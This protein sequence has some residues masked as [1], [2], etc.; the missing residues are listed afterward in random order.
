MG[1]PRGKRTLYDSGLHVPLLI[2]FPKKWQHLPQASPGLTIDQLVSFVDFAPT[3]LS[4]CGVK[5]PTHMQGLVFLGSGALQSRQHAFGSRDRVD[6]AFDLSRSAR[7]GRWLYIRNFMPHLSWMQPEGYSDTSVF[8]QEFKRLATAGKLSAGPATYATTQRTREELYDTEADP[9]QLHNLAGAPAHKEQLEALRHALREWQVS[10]RDAGFLTEPQMWSLLGDAGTPFDLAKDAA[11]YPQLRLLDAADLV[12]R[13]DVITQ[14]VKLLA[15]AD[16]GVRY[17]AAVGL[18]A[19]GSP[20]AP[21]REGLRR[22]LGDSS[23]VV[24]V[25]AA[26][27]LVTLNETKAA[28]DV[29]ENELRASQPEVVLHAARTL[30]QLGEASR[31][32]LSAMR[33]ALERARKNEAQD[34]LSM[35]IRFSLETALAN[36]AGQNR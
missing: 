3:V 9:H 2:R 34:V 19:S 27:A 16:D 32:L 12:G 35:F 6:E 13:T 11:R 24:R 28:L 20:G 33:A 15:D 7:D 25:E 10:T 18:R 5:N 21:A 1:M 30:E 36:L 26:A 8:R 23:A 17:W 14:Q 31:P 29:L 4:L 22:A